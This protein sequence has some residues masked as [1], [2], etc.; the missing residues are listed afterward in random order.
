MTAEAAG[1]GPAGRV[2]RLALLLPD[3]AGG[4]VERN[5]LALAA[6]FLERGLAVDLLVLRAEGPL[7]DEVPSGV[8]LLP[9]A[10]AGDWQGRVAAL[11]A[12]PAGLPRLLLPVLLAR[13]PPAAYRALPALARYLREERPRALI[14]A[15]PFENLLAIA[16]RRLAGPAAAGTRVVVSERNATTASTRR[17]RKW[18]RRH[19]PALLRRQY[20]MADAVVAVSADLADHLARE[21]GLPRARIATV[22]NPVVTPDLA[23]KAAEAPDHPWFRPGQPPVVLGVGRL[24]P[25]K[26][27]PTLLRAFARV[28]ARREARLVILGHGI[29]EARAGLEELAR[30]LGCGADLDLPGFVRNPFAF[31]ARAGVFAL[32]S[33]HEGLP[34]VLIQALACGCPVVSTDCP[35]GPAEIL[36]EGRLGPLVPVGDDAALAL[37][38]A[39]ALDRPPAADREARIARG[40]AFGVDR[41]VDRYLALIEGTAANP[42]TSAA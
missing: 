39:A 13:S 42:P 19:L 5:T 15:F 17:G 37:A 18:K 33:L 23:A 26:D 22:H 8:R 7:L 29:D 38:I 21:T 9:L 16:A 1:S 25:Q 2:D 32:S 28:R 3:L 31:M 24:V 27:F 12:D 11:R 40:R 4:G 6:G 34:G 10:A 20:P 41:A 36:E 30:E 35:T 14:A